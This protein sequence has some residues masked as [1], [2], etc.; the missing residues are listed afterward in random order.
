MSSFGLTF[1]YDLSKTFPLL[2]TKKM[3]VRAIF[4][5]LMFYLSGKTD[6]S[7]LNDKGITIWNGNT[8][9]EFLDKSLQKYHQEQ[10]KQSDLTHS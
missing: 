6:N 2:T 7:I 10:S 1:K 9:R 4:E 5:E 8:T 3:W